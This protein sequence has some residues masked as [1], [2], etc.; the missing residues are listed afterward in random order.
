[1]THDR[2]PERDVCFIK[3]R[4][5]G[6]ATWKT[7]SDPAPEVVTI[8]NPS[9][10]ATVVCHGNG[11]PVRSDGVATAGPSAAPSAPNAR[12]AMADWSIAHVN[13]N[14]SMPRDRCWRRSFAG[15]RPKAGVRHVE[16]TLPCTALLNGVHG[17]IQ[18]DAIDRRSAADF[19][20]GTSSASRSP[21]RAP[22]MAFVFAIGC[23][24]ELLAVPPPPPEDAAADVAPDAAPIV[25]ASPPKPLDCAHP[26]SC[27]DGGCSDAGP[28]PAIALVQGQP[29]VTG[30]VTDGANVYWAVNQA[31][32]AI[33]ACST[34]GCGG[35]PF[36]LALS[37]PNPIAIA[38]DGATIYWLDGPNEQIRK[39][40]TS[41]CAAPG[42]VLA[43][44]FN[45]WNTFGAGDGQV[46]FAA[47]GGP[48][49]SCPESGCAA[50][51]TI[52]PVGSLGA[53][54]VGGSNVYWRDSSTGDVLACDAISCASPTV[55]ASG[56]GG[57]GG[58]SANACGA[59]W[60]VANTNTV[61]TCPSTG[62]PNGPI[63]FASG[64][65][66]GTRPIA[67]DDSGVYWAT[68][69]GIVSCE[70]GGCAQPRLLA[71]ATGSASAIALDAS[72]VYWA[73]KGAVWK[74]S[75]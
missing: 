72:N 46:F 42:I 8:E 73:T 10:T 6:H 52:A 7:E 18:D 33:M 17:S 67:V 50:Y 30:L 61:M 40:P 69:D 39:C 44:L 11:Q 74:V 49:S 16:V 38:I 66:S 41:G 58:I 53:V 14:E 35:V 71:K 3:R 15:G 2:T 70:L 54:A 23:G 1:M 4:R 63:T 20:G 62:C 60:T 37:Q 45:P 25:D 48:F 59:Y 57:F 64:T 29:D 19:R 51:T 21:M 47:M 55:L 5:Y 65:L 43:G 75:K 27:L 56:Q 31:I 24:G 68:V 34:S 32:G 22:L 13:A 9:P 12:Y 28:Q 36:P 26:A